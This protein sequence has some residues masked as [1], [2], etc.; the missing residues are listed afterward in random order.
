M[1]NAL[2]LFLLSIIC[3]IAMVI[4]I[5]FG[6]SSQFAPDNM[7]DKL[8]P[9]AASQFYDNRG[10]LIYTTQSEEKRLPITFEKIPKHVRDAFVAIEDNRFYE[11]SGIDYRATARAL[12]STLSGQEVQGGSTI[13]QQ[14]AKNAFLTQERSIKRKIKEAFIARELERKYT[15]DEI[16]TMYL[17]HIYFGHGSYGLQAASQFYF[18]KDCQNLSIAEAATLAAIPKSPNYYNPYGNKE[19]AKKRRMLVIDQMVKYN[20]ITQ[21]EADK[22]KA[23]NVK[24]DAGT[25]AQKNLRGYFYDMV[26]AEIVDKYGADALYKGGMKVYTTLDPDMQQAAENAI[27]HLPNYYTDGNNLIQPQVGLVAVEPRTGYVKAVVGGRGQDQF[28]RATLATR[29]PGSAMK[30]FVYLTAMENGFTPATVISEKNDTGAYR[31]QGADHGSITVRTAVAHSYNIAAV[32][33]AKQVGFSRILDTAE[34]L[35][36]STLV[37]EGK[38]KDEH[39]AM[40]L[41]GIYNGVKPI[42][43]ASAY[44]AIGLNGQ[45]VKASCIEKILDRDGKVIYEN[46]QVPK[47]TVN[48]GAAYLTTNMLQD[49]I[50]Y[51][52]AAHNTGGG[53][54]RPAAGKT[55]TTDN[56]VDA[57]FVGYT[58]DLSCAVWVGD[59]NSKPLDLY[60]PGV[61]VTIWRDFMVNALANVPASDF[62]N[63]GVVV[64]TDPEIKKE[65]LD[66]DGKPIKRDKDGKIIKDDKNSEKP[67]V[68]TEPK[69]K[70]STKDKAKAA[71]GKVGKEIKKI[72]GNKPKKEQF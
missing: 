44:G 19:E 45:Y 35:G 52:T 68:S 29:Q 40:A 15:K 32:N 57:W 59:D 26:I 7:E 60:G 63:P 33:V 66:K 46:K 16:L 10:H 31:P 22:A 18:G 70:K 28:N 53:I 38:Y 5:F 8:T 48:P 56:G 43:M 47:S 42:E 27:R 41:G 71:M 2:K 4:S 12:V 58:P 34:K 17:N 65:E 37:R 14:L 11:H 50:R 24:F 51:G 39:P 55:G 9:D 64:P 21:A 13:T 49:V 6:F 3:L 23:E 72:V 54:G 69:K 36:I 30:T 67:V 62:V 1:L 25:K 20:L 61:P